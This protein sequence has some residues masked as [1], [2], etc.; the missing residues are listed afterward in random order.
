[1]IKE[2][3][4]TTST[5]SIHRKKN[6]IK[7]MILKKIPENTDELKIFV[8]LKK[9]EKTQHFKNVVVMYSFLADLIA[10]LNC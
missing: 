10:K 2:T 8:C 4:K 7:F 1:V 3:S 6:A 9:K 5:K